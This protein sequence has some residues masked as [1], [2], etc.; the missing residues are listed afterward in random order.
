MP[1]SITEFSCLGELIQLALNM[2]WFV[3][4][5]VSYNISIF[6]VNRQMT[7]CCILGNSL[8]FSQMHIHVNFLAV[9][10]ERASNLAPYSSSRMQ[11]LS[12]HG[13]GLPEK[14]QVSRLAGVYASIVM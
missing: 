1:G 6:N 13:G 7:C 3:D 10:S 14:L 5:V 8:M 4:R 12:W 2:F 9:R 11:L